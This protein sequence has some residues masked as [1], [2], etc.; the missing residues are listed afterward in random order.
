MKRFYFRDESN[1]AEMIKRARIREG[2]SQND[3]ARMTGFSAAS[4]S[5]WESGKRA[6]SVETFEAIMAALGGELHVVIE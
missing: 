3:L 4:I 2:L 6:P 5:R 1:A